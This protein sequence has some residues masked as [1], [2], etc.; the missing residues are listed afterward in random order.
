MKRNEVKQEYCWRLSDIFASVIEWERE[1]SALNRDSVGILRFKG[2]LADKTILRE[3]LIFLDEIG[4]RLEKLYAYARLTSDENLSET[5]G[6]E[7]KSKVET[8]AVQFNSDAS[9]VTPELANL[10]GETLGA[11]AADPDFSDYDYQLNSIIKQKKHILSEETE[12]VLALAGKTVGAFSEIFGQID[13][14]DLPLPSIQIDGKKVQMTH[15]LYG[16]W[17]HSPDRGLRKRAFDGMYKA[18]GALVNTTTA[19][20]A[21]SVNKDNFLAQAR[22]Y[23]SALEKKLDGTDVPPSVYE[24]LVSEVGKH[25][26]TLHAYMEFRKKTL[27]VEALHMY[28][29]HVPL[30]E[31]A[32][33]ALSFD[34]A[35]DTVLNGL[36]PMGGEYVSLLRRARAERWIDV[37]ETEN[38]HSGAYS[39]GVYGVHPY[40]LLNYTP[41]THDVFT[42]AHEMGHAMHSYYSSAAQPYAK[43]DYAIFVAEVA[44]TVNEVLLLKY[45]LKTARDEKMK[46]FLLSYYLDM[47]RTTLFR[48][49]MFAEF[50][51]D[52]HTAESIGTP[53]TTEELGK[54]YLRLNKKYYGA[55]VSHDRAIR[56]EWARIPHFY[57]A[58]YVYQ[59]ATGLT[60]A[61]NIAGAILTEGETAV[62]RY[63]EFLSA[64][65]HKSPYEILRDVGVDLAVARPY[66]VAFGEFEAT[67]TELKS[68]T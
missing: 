39:Y 47:F 45:L 67:L 3:C 32:D 12:R 33:L 42:I 29:L 35:Y 49:T 15:G 44:S 60:S 7:L 43:N 19:N 38:K 20:F 53:L 8:L 31:N 56:L 28:D 61:V 51:A 21:A 62:R 14:V 59:Y 1:L 46:K 18:V 2:R 55:K 54:R 66:E 11:L 9:F 23:G 30:F 68:L 13:D 50:E 6:A 63:K 5:K 16:L 22:R 36:S 34:E 26:K 4:K 24:R 52:I 17:L 41:T 10:D 27:G 65:G 57:R 48:Q 40:V 37:E 25:L 64:G 58:F